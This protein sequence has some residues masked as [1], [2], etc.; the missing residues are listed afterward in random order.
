MSASAMASGCDRFETEG[1]ELLERGEPLAEHFESCQDCV[2]ARRTYEILADELARPLEVRP[3]GTWQARVWSE[4]ARRQGETQ[5]SRGFWR[6]W[7]VPVGALGAAA[8]ALLVLWIP[9]PSPPDASPA[10][11]SFEVEWRPQVAAGHRGGGDARPGDFLELRATLDA[12][13][14]AELRLYRD[15]L[16]L[17]VQCRDEPPCR[18]QGDTLEARFPLDSRGVYQPILLI[19][20]APLEPGSGDLDADLGAAFEAGARIELSSPITVR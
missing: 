8:T 11:V 19:S 4:V 14:E 13:S 17:A 9:Q 10:L 7:W 18:R 12:S 16:E 20:S 1:L 15:D 3:P 2:E 6:R 5:S